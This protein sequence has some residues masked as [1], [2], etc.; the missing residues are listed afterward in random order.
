M[1]QQASAPWWKRLLWLLLIWGLSVLALGSVA[2]ALRG[3]M[4]LAGLHR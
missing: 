2:Y 3:F 1:P 4:S